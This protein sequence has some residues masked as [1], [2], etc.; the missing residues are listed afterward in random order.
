MSS[1]N[2]YNPFTATGRSNIKMAIYNNK[3]TVILLVFMIVIVIVVG[4]LWVWQTPI[5]V[6]TPLE[7][8]IPPPRTGQGPFGWGTYMPPKEILEEY[9]PF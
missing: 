8:D 3:E 7:F 4:M 1:T 6:H 2:E 5:A 9:I